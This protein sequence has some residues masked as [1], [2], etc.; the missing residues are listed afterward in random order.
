MSLSRLSRFPLGDLCILLI[1]LAICSGM[2]GC[3]VI[4]VTNADVIEHYYPGIAVI[5]VFPTSSA[6]SVLSIRGIGLTIG[7]RGGTFGYLKETTFSAPDQAVCRTFIVVELEEQ[8]Q[9][10]LDVLKNRNDLQ[11]L[12]VIKEPKGKKP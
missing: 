7:A 9:A 4:Q 2:N 8:A 11:D 5:S 3:A 1:S 10:L 12:C 6:T